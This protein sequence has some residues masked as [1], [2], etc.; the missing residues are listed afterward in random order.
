MNNIYELL[1]EL[2]L[3]DI[4]LWVE[5]GELC[6]DDYQNNLS[7]TLRTKIKKNKE[8]LIEFLSNNNTRYEKDF[9]PIMKQE[10]LSEY[11]L[12]INQQQLWFFDQLQIPSS[13]Y[14][15]P[16]A[17]NIKGCIDIPKLENSFNELIKR[18]DVLRTTFSVT[19]GKPVQRITAYKPISIPIQD[20]QF[21]NKKE[22]ESY[23]FENACV[24]AQKALYL[25]N[26]P[27]LRPVIWILGEERTILQITIHH[28]ISDAWSMNVLMLE[29]LL[30]YEYIKANAQVT[31][32]E[33]R[34]HYKDYSLWQNKIIDKDFFKKQ[35]DYWKV[36]LADYPMVMALPLDRP[37]PKVQTFKGNI[38]SFYPKKQL[39][40]ALRELCRKQK[41]TIF[42]IL[43]TAFQ[44]LLYHYTHQTKSVMGFLNSNRSQE[45]Q[46]SIGFYV[47]TCL[48]CGDLS[49][50]LPFTMLLKK[51][52]IDFIQSF[53][54]SDVPFLK[55][56]EHL[57]V[58]RN[59][60]HNP[61]FQVLI[62]HETEQKAISKTLNIEFNYF[63]VD[64]EKSKFDLTLFIN[65]SNDNF[66]LTIEYNSDIFDTQTIE[67]LLHHYEVLL[68]N[69]VKNPE[70]PVL[71]ISIFSKNDLHDILNQFNDTQIDY[72][73]NKNIIQLFE[74]QVQR[75]PDNIAIISPF[76]KNIQNELTYHQLNQRANQLANYL[77]NQHIRHDDLVA[78]YMERSLEMVISLLG[79]L[80]AGA[81][82]VPIDPDYP[83]ERILYMLEDSNTSILLT[84]KKLQPL[85]KCRQTKV[86]TLDTD[87]AIIA[88]NPDT[89]P[90]IYAC[91]EH[92]AYVIYTS[93]STGKP[94]GVMNIHQGICNRLH[95][96][97]QFFQLSEKDHVLQKTPFSFDVSVWEFFWP[98]ITGARLVMAKPGGHKDSSYLM[99]V[100]CEQQ[101]S[102]IHFVPSML[103]LFLKK[104]KVGICDHYLK[105]VICSGEALGVDL[106]NNF[107]NIFDNASL[108]NLYGPTE[109]AIDV[110]AWKCKIIRGQYNRVPIGK[111]IA[112]TQ[113]YILGSKMKPVP[114]GVDGELHIGGVNLA[115]GYLNR[116]ELTKEKFI[117]NIFSNNKNSKLYKTG[118]KARYL[119]DGTIEYLGRLD[120]QVKIRGFRIELGEIENVLLRQP[121]VNS[122]VV[123][124][125]EYESSI[126][127]LVAY[128]EPN[129]KSLSVTELRN[130]LKIHVPE[131]MIPT[132]F[133]FMDRIPL[134]PNGKVDYSKLPLP[135]TKRPHLDTEYVSAQTSIQKTLVAIWCNVLK[136]DKIGI[137]DNFF[138]LG[139]DS[140]RSLQVLYLSAEKGL[141]FTL[142][143]IFQFQTI[144]ELSKIIDKNN[145]TDPYISKDYQPF[146]LI[147]EKD[148]QE[149]PSGLDDAYPLSLLQA[150]LVFHSN[151]N[152]DAYAAYVT[153]YCLKSYFDSKQFY[154]ALHSTVQSHP[155]LRTSFDF[156]NFTNP[157][158][159]IHKSVS[160]NF[161]QMDWKDMPENQQRNLLGKWINNI[162]KNK[163]NWEQS[164]LFRFYIH[165]LSN[166]SFQ[167]TIVE[168]ILDGWSVALLGSEI[169]SNYKLLLTGQKI[170][171]NYLQTT[172]AD[173]IRSE[174]NIVTSSKFKEFWT[175][176][177][178]QCTKSFLPKLPKKNKKHRYIRKP[179]QV[180]QSIG[181][182]IKQ[183][184]KS[185]S[186]P[187]KTVLLAVHLRVLVF[188]TGQTSITT[189]LMTNVRQ[190]AR[191]GDRVIGLFLN[192]IP[193]G[194]ELT[195]NC[196]WY[197]F[198]K[199]VFTKELEL[200][201]YRRYPLAKIQQESG[202]NL[203]D[204]I[205]NFIHFYPY[206]EFNEHPVE[207][208]NIKANDQTYFPLTVQF[209][210]NWRT[211]EIQLF[212][213]FNAGDIFDEQIENIAGYYSK[214]LTHLAYNPHDDYLSKGLLSKQEQYKILNEW[215]QNRLIA[216]SHKIFHQL[217]EE[218]VINTP[219]KLAAIDAER[220][221][222]YEE[223]NAQANCLARALMLHGV[224]DDY[225]V[226]LLVNRNI[227]FLIAILAIFKAGGAYLPIHPDWPENRISQILNQ[228]D[229]EMV[230]TSCQFMS[231][232]EATLKNYTDK[233][234]P[235]LLDINTLLKEK[236]S[237]TNLSLEYHEHHI[238]YIIFTSGSTGTPKG[239]MIEHKGMLN[240]LYAKIEDLHLN[241]NSVVAQTASQCFDISIWQFLCCLLTGGTVVIADEYTAQD[242]VKLVQFIN[243][244]RINVFETIPSLLKTI[245]EEIHLNRI[246]LSGL[247]DLKWLLVTGEAFPADLCNE[248]FKLY[249][250]IPV[251]NAYGPTE[252]SDDVT[253]FIINSP[254]L[255]DFSTVPIG[256]PVRNTQIYILDKNYQP[257]P[258]GASGELFVGGEGVGRGYLNNEKQTKKAF[259]SNPFNP[260]KL[261]YRT[262]DMARFLANG[263]IEFLGRIDHQ[264]KIRG[265]RIEIGEIE[266]TLRKHKYIKDAVVVMRTI[267]NKKML[268]GFIVLSDKGK[269]IKQNEIKNFLRKYLPE[270]M[271]PFILISVD[272][273]PLNQN[274]KIDHKALP[275]I[276][277]TMLDIDENVEYTP[278]R[279]NIEK[280]IIKIWKEV[281]GTERIGIYDNFYELGGNSLQAVQL[282][283]KMSIILNC[284]IS[285]K[286]LFA[287]PTP[288]SIA[289]FLHTV[290][291]HNKN[292]YYS[293]SA[294]KY[295]EE[296]KNFT[297]ITLESR[298]L[299]K[300]INTG[301]IGPVHAVAFG[302]LSP[303]I[304]T[305]SGLSK[306]DV[307]HGWFHDLPDIK[308]IYFTPLG[309]ICHIILPIF[310][311]DIYYNPIDLLKVIADG[312]ELAAQLGACTVSLTGLIPSATDYGHTIINNIK[313]IS[314]KN[315]LPNITTGHATTTAAVIYAVEK[316]LQE[317]GRNI[318]QEKVGFIGLGSIG[319]SSLKLMLSIMEPPETINLC[320]IYSKKE[321]LLKIKEKIIKEL[322]FKG[323]IN[324]FPTE[325]DNIPSEFYDSTLI[326]GATNIPDILD[327]CA[328][329][330]GTLIVDDSA[331]H[332]FNP[333][334]AIKRFEA[335]GD[336]LFTEGGILRLPQPIE[337]IRYSPNVANNPFDGMVNYRHSDYDIMGC[338]FSSLLPNA[339]QNMK[340]VIGT[341]K[342]ETCIQ[343]YKKFKELDYKGPSLCCKEY[344]LD[345][346]KIRNF[347]IR[348]S[349][350]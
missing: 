174:L 164:S 350:Y 163:F 224:R 255:E 42:Q 239:A 116:P 156:V 35:L 57:Q 14:N 192:V 286:Y 300:L 26:G 284:D 307:I 328:L 118:D 193:L 8:K 96:M 333:E 132:A 13:V 305:I 278:P 111:P 12:S 253:H 321:L 100:I 306:S 79:I 316:L 32:P 327:I 150:G 34:T 166:N 86:I 208:I 153:S 196:N 15:I 336:I 212:L 311:T 106:Q 287:N 108:Y 171:H 232:L 344:L 73:L 5:N 54:N 309:S 99:E 58:E 131:Y 299:L 123:V 181:E 151:N 65:E 276:N 78:V 252:C 120:S 313:K 30:I 46:D 71:D 298:P 263:D 52:M 310:S 331:P 130:F 349:S 167:F 154:Q 11:P 10:D 51:N 285:I 85:L 45:T 92:I 47:A 295:N 112:N 117:K 323:K 33:V 177:T 348:F 230:L 135:T 293:H 273:L 115:R 251:V 270:Y 214:A 188:I 147:S 101:I 3:S 340:P 277:L 29:L 290:K 172:Y 140:I 50:N 17:I 250:Q 247:T 320:D 236:H 157:L 206:Q 259:I 330:P 213:D 165:L 275:P 335:D 274:G 341:V 55:I 195:N 133:V 204:V 69:I 318:I 347:K 205:F 121:E 185:L 102:T 49:N 267:N 176:Q 198:I 312:L 63:L 105:Q 74:E 162:K 325:K 27:L 240:H 148:Y 62:A 104:H 269:K 231:K 20:L 75:T 209:S 103:R 91:P 280:K 146:S 319:L 61:I 329:K 243:N 81:A 98:L 16:G 314:S 141:T 66:Y 7:N 338:I 159:L 136:I 218:Q 283:S 160:V 87:W 18:H 122:A 107:L 219:N 302:Y 128:V 80:K 242:P 297:C 138:D 244:S 137:Y 281:L 43:F 2:S 234:I 24:E 89:N 227:D 41:T 241:E 235:Q 142:P 184:A 203:F 1:T 292:D 53:K 180:P 265:F 199:I 82:Y 44:I 187:L 113:I 36:Q 279:N 271:I 289:E 268:A 161:K 266:S 337:E 194:L 6:Y 334:E 144:D 217:F 225:V 134:S 303:S 88:D 324:I 39:K 94:K 68:S 189:G 124:V 288:A 37:R 149:L 70:L 77:R 186:V 296:I 246:P 60:A 233:T 191:D 97:Q 21:M 256:R 76:L 4:K 56:V 346:N 155:M 248:W 169:L 183:L 168:P 95:W 207:L 261:F 119:P 90:L 202:G 38:K 93:G 114:I 260:G 315:N 64:Y 84:Q 229:S 59:L 28:I 83:K 143:D 226:S 238:A 179:V 228:S 22:A 145:E 343:R 19:A 200:M 262:G 158:Q 322:S 249:P 237:K 173:Y 317:S 210:L 211:D 339:F 175:K 190:E 31:L 152:P 125:K 294:P 9:P 139:G 291:L 182:R 301:K 254:L 345:E 126:Q 67:R 221:L 127:M 216:H 109:A 264:I 129:N 257:L 215:N 282:V 245:I 23:F 178:A 170:K 40:V 110:T 272:K 332:C 220:Q 48:L 304:L 326:V 258:V 342:L 25:I 223:L 201:A 197:N 222:T 308:S 72:P